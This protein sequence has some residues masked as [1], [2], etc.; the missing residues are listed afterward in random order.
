M[1]VCACTYTE[2]E[3]ANRQ[4]PNN[5]ITIELAPLKQSSHF[6]IYGSIKTFVITD[7]IALVPSASAG[8]DKYGM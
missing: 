1:S 7:S 2:N 5:L 3:R 6:L 8:L 4:V